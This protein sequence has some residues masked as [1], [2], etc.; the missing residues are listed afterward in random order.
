MEKFEIEENL[1][2]WASLLKLNMKDLLNTDDKI[3][4]VLTVLLNMS[5][6]HILFAREL[7]SHE[8]IVSDLH[9]VP[10]VETEL[11]LKFLSKTVYV[12]P[13]PF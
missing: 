12:L 8:L 4:R 11:S 6:R 5:I 3:W 9:N 1:G 7:T 10:L 13:F 2:D